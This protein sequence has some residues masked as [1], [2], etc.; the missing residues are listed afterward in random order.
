MF[1]VARLPFFLHSL[2]APTRRFLYLEIAEASEQTSV[3]TEP[4]PTRKKKK[5]KRKTKKIH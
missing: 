2:P 1:A 4:L 5:K 3:D